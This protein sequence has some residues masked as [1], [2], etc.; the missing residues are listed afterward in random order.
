MASIEEKSQRRRPP[1]FVKYF[2]QK[3]V[4][5]E[6]YSIESLQ[7]FQNEAVRQLVAR[8]Y[9]RNPFY[10]QKMQ[11]AGLRPKDIQTTADLAR[12]P[13]TTKDELRQDPWILLACDRRE[14]AVIY[15]STGT[16][17]GKEIYLPWTW[18][19]YYRNE[20]TPAMA[21]LVDEGPGD[22]V[23]NAL[24]YEMSSAGL[25]FHKVFID[26][27]GATVI[28]AGKGGAYSSPE[29]T[30]RLMQDIPPTVI[31]TTPSYAVTLAET[32]KACG[33]D[34]AALPLRKMWLTGEGCSYAFRS[35]VEAL[36]NTRANF[37]YGSLECGALGIECDS[38]AGYHIPMAHSYVEIV[39]PDSGRVLEPGEIGEIVVTNL[40]RRDTPLIRYRTQDL[41]YIETERCRCGVRLPRLFL[42]GRMVDQIEIRGI[43]FSPFY[44][45]E[46]LMRMPEVGNWYHFVV[47]RERDVLKVRTELAEGVE[48][49]VELA[50]RLASELEFH[51]GVPCRFE[52]VDQIPR[53]RGKTVRVIHE[54]EEGDE[55]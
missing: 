18:H 47:P 31:M 5:V 54:T 45:E 29:K 8:A 42:R 41:G 15:V 32:A 33:I 40:L 9:A 37:Y 2:G 13:F 16:T 39:D 38:H 10:R 20:L 23:L 53:P 30:V 25:A 34:L 28:P 1:L 55:Q 48:P 7:L 24:P 22:I 46:F 43:S 27:C 19:D 14:I 51:V 44:L 11:S 17:G 36:W 3:G 26:G 4:T 12:M 6:D 50:E 52:F 21:K 35:R 49:T